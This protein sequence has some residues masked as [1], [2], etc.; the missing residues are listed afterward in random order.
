MNGDHW[1]LLR[2]LRV[3]SLIVFHLIFYFYELYVSST[4]IV[5]SGLFLLNKF[6][7]IGRGQ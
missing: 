2:T 6:W 1:P 4:W 5:K 7:V 3:D